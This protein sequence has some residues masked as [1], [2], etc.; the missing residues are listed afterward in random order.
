[1]SPTAISAD[2]FLFKEKK[3]VIKTNVIFNSGNYSKANTVRRISML[4]KSFG[5]KSYLY[6]ALQYHFYLHQ[7]HFW[8]LF[9]QGLIAV[10]RTDIFL[11][12]Y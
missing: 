1:M 4:S 5:S 3:K 7:L 9:P 11:F 6:P 12:I 2:H 8:C 10:V